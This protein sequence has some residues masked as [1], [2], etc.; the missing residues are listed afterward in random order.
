MLTVV[1]VY[2]IAGRRFRVLWHP[3]S[4]VVAVSAVGIVVSLLG[5]VL[6]R[7][8]AGSMTDML[9][10]SAIGSVGWG[11]VIAAVVWVGRRLL[12]W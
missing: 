8:D 1:A 5:M 10:R 4:I 2:V 7:H 11:L 6:F 12:R 9:R 3:L